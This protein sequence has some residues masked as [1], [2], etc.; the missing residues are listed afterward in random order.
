MFYKFG[1]E[2]NI[3]YISSKKWKGFSSSLDC[4]CSPVYYNF[5][6]RLFVQ[7][8]FQPAATERNCR[9]SYKVQ[10]LS[11]FF[12]PHIFNDQLCAFSSFTGLS[13]SFSI[14]LQCSEPQNF[15]FYGRDHSSGHEMS[16]LNAKQV[17]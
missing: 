6:G 12:L 8:I 5:F 14:P 13:L 17:P 11:F 4:R 2:S 16:P 10:L 1:R 15:I 3:I 7:V 9:A